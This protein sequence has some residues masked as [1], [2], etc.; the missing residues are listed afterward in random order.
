[1]IENYYSIVFYCLLQIVI[2]F[3][4]ENIFYLNMF[5]RSQ[6]N[7]YTNR[8]FREERIKTVQGK[9]KTEEKIKLILPS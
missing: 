3:R 7:S 6:S 9:N 4:N 1:M 8:S 5:R 2:L